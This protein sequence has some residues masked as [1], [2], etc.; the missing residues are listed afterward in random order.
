SMDHTFHSGDYILTSKISYK[1]GEPKRG[2]VIVFRSPRNPDIDYIK[3]IIGLPG[4]QIRING[5]DVY[6]NNQLL[7]ETYIGSATSIM[8]GGF[9]QDGIDVVV[10]PDHLFVMGDNR[11]RSSDSREFGFIPQTDVIGKVFFRYLPYD[12]FGKI[13]NPYEK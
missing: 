11:A 6:V 12:K 3:R 2:D 5:N 13:E 1:F 9:M 10:P 7:Q 8:G 4:D